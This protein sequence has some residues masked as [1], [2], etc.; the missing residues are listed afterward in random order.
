M[1]QKGEKNVTDYEFVLWNEEA[2][3]QEA[4]DSLCST[5]ATE[6]I[7]ANA[8]HSAKVL[9]DLR[10]FLSDFKIDYKNG[11]K[12]IINMAADFNEAL[13]QKYEELK[14]NYLK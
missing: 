9:K 14:N 13:P 6:F 3:M 5:V 11:T 8:I 1:K 2:Q 10:E 12:S 7:G 4:F